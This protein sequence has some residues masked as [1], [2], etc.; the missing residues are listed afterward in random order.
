MIISGRAKPQHAANVNEDKI[1]HGNIFFASELR[2]RFAVSAR[3]DE[4]ERREDMVR[5]QAWSKGAQIWSRFDPS[6]MSLKIWRLHWA[7][8]QWG[9]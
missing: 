7:C 6:M 5:C 9:L 4:H 1:D 2:V 3:I 8:I